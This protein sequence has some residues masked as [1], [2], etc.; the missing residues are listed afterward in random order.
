MQVKNTILYIYFPTCDVSQW[1]S[2]NAERNSTD[3]CLSSLSNT[4]VVA[5]QYCDI[6]MFSLACAG[7]Y[8]AREN[9]NSLLS[10]NKTRSGASARNVLFLICIF[11]IVIPRTL[12]VIV[13][14]LRRCELCR[15]L[16]SCQPWDFDNWVGWYILTSS[17]YSEQH[18]H[19]LTTYGVLLIQ[20]LSL[21]YL[22]LT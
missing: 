21:I 5:A 6:C 9:G 13:A 14:H 4:H 1:Q 10:I 18:N 11:Q 12:L 3:N 15:S 22:F 7:V 2:T 20:R 19:T 17:T 16:N 8:M